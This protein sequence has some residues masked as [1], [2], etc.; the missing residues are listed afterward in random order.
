[1][2]EVHILNQEFGAVDKSKN[3][4]FFFMSMP[5]SRHFSPIST[6]A[7]MSDSVGHAAI[8]QAQRLL[9]SWRVPNP[10]AAVQEEGCRRAQSLL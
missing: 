8:E 9:K 4:F 5:S 2:A 3:V 7:N 10:G 1:L 6:A